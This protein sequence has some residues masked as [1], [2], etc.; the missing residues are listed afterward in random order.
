MGSYSKL[1]CSTTS[2]DPVTS[3]EPRSRSLTATASSKSAN[4]A[5]V[6]TLSL[7]EWI[8]IVWFI[9]SLSGFHPKDATSRVA[10][11]MAGDSVPLVHR[12]LGDIRVPVVCAVLIRRLHQAC[13]DSQSLEAC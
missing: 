12:V 6:V 1:R 7:F 11:L 10:F 13:R 5:Q 9:L 3:V 8:S 2:A 4:S